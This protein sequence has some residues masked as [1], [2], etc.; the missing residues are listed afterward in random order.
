M[1]QVVNYPYRFAVTEET[2]KAIKALAEK[3]KI[4]ITKLVWENFREFYT[5]DNEIDLGK[6]NVFIF[7]NL[8]H[9]STGRADKNVFNKGV[10]FRYSPK[11]DFSELF[12]T[13]EEMTVGKAGF[14][15]ACIAEIIKE[16]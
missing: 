2:H 15:R 1:S 12:A 4:T 8:S 14:V 7:N 9:I 13:L 6:L 3:K 16:G 5:E 11:L 10:V